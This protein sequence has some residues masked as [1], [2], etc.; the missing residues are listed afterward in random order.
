[1]PNYI[2]HPQLIR[3]CLKSD[4]IQYIGLFKIHYQNNKFLRVNTP[5]AML[6]IFSFPFTDVKRITQS[7]LSY[8]TPVHFEKLLGENND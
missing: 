2:R 3:G 8:I 6:A 1:M 5:T 7:K 4:A